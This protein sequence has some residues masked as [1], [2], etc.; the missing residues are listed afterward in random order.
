MAYIG[1]HMAILILVGI[2]SLDVTGTSIASTVLQFL[3]AV[4]M[5]P[6]SFLDHSRSPRPSILMSIYLLLTLLFDIT[7]ARTFWL[8]SGTR[9]ELTY[10]TVFTA[11]VALKVVILFLEAQRKTRFVKWDSK[12]H[13]P[14]ETSGIYSLGAYLWLN[15]LFSHGYSRILQM[16]D[17]YPLDFSMRGKALHEHFSKH[18]DFTQMKGRTAGLLRIL[19]RTLA[20]PLLLP[21]MPRLALMGFMFCQPLFIESLLTH[22]A[23]PEAENSSNIGYGYIGAAFLIYR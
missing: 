23:K 6:L 19:S 17:L 15:K 18:A 4:C 1:L 16:D 3:A 11:S 22:L 5:V 9:P 8:A 2:R 7:Q 20:V 10:T 12:E 14:E 13:S 21:V